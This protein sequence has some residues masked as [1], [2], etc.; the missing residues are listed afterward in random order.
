[1]RQGVTDAGLD[2]IHRGAVE[3]VVQVQ[4]A[5]KQRLLGQRGFQDGQGVR[6]TGYGR[7]AAAVEA[8]HAQ[9]VAQV[10]QG[11]QRLCLFA[12]D[13]QRRHAA[14]ALRLALQPAALEN[15]ADRVG[16]R[17]RAAGPGCGHFANAVADNGRRH[18]APLRQHAR[19]ADL[20]REQRGLG[21][22]SAGV[23]V[24]AIFA[25]QFFMQREIGVLREQGVDFVDRRGEDGVSQQAAAHV[26][27]LGTVAGI[28]HHRAVGAVKRRAGH[29]AVMRVGV[30]GELF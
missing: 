28:D 15:D 3:G 2:G 10:V 5:E 25:G 9:L 21:N 6:R 22:F 20:Q 18:D 17:K 27:P 12:A 7:P 11:D 26:R 19:D 23:A 1:M 30:A 24:V 4:A 16:Q 14:V 29:D 8:R 13:T